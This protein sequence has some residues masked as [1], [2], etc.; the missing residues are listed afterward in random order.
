MFDFIIVGAGF[1][2]S[3]IAERVANLLNK[4]VLI[5]EKRNHIGGNCYDFYNERGILIHKYGPHIFYTNKKNV[6]DYISQF[7]EWYYYQHKVLGVIDGRKVPIPFNLNSL[8]DLFPHKLANLLEEKLIINFG[9]GKRVSILKLMNTEDKDLRLLSDYVYEK[10]FLNYTQ[11]QWGVRPEELDSSVMERVP[12]YISRDNRYFQDRYQGIPKEGYYKIFERMLSS[13]NIKIL[14]NTDFRE[15]IEIDYEE[16]KIY[17]LGKEFR[18]KLIFTG[19]IDE[20]FNY[21]YGR[22][23]YRSLRFK[24]ETIE[25]D[26]Y[27]EVAV[28]NYP[29]EYEFT[30]ITEFKYLTGQKANITT[31]AIEYPQDYDEK[32]PDKNIPFYPILRKENIE[33]YKKYKA[34]AVSFDNVI[35]I[36]RLGE[37]R[38]YN[39]SEVINSG[40]SIIYNNILIKG[41]K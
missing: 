6:W 18:G 8:Y 32:D 31:I 40:L 27:Q 39:M 13:P 23:P 35:F 1:S 9:Y 2:G 29:N 7:T 38:Y 28:V 34:Q 11:K 12:I 37:Y 22:L 33:I 15:V 17:F 5:V 26:Y 14:L 41:V 20:F 4:K 16:K 30:R 25:K 21:K 3:V 36:G 19:P 24:F 10:V